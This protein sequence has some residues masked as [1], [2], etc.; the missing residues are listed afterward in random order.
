MTA[1]STLHTSITANGP[2]GATR[3]VQRPAHGCPRTIR[4]DKA[5]RPPPG[6][7]VRTDRIE[8]EQ[9]EHRPAGGQRKSREAGD[10]DGRAAGQAGAEDEQR[11]GRGFLRPANVERHRERRQGDHEDEIPPGLLNQR[12]DGRPIDPDGRHL[13]RSVPAQVVGDGRT[14]RGR[15]RRP[16]PPSSRRPPIAVTT[17]P[18][19]SHGAPA[20]GQRH[21]RQQWTCRHRRRRHTAESAGRSAKVRGPPGSRC[22]GHRLADKITRSENRPDGRQS[23]GR[24]HWRQMRNREWPIVAVGLALPA[25]RHRGG[26]VAVLGPGLVRAA[27]AGTICPRCGTD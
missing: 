21:D 15:L 10:H 16:R 1:A 13:R 4:S 2:T 7:R 12:P 9:P 6:D 11:S 24:R 23:V 17:S 18:V 3:R 20:T 14:R 19:P 27:C 8:L 25:I 5:S 22:S 26:F